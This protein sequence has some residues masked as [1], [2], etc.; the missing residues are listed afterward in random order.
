MILTAIAWQKILNGET[1]HRFI[2]VR[3]PPHSDKDISSN[4][5]ALADMIKHYGDRGLYKIKD[6]DFWGGNQGADG[7][8]E[9]FEPFIG[10]FSGCAAD[11]T[12]EVKQF[13]M[14]NPI[15]AR[16]THFPLEIGYCIPDQIETHLSTARCIARLPYGSRLIIFMENVS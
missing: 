8:I 14:A 10:I 11:S 7:F 12:E 3:E 5:A 9:F 1:I 6:A 2:E 16:C 13:A 15:H 4:K